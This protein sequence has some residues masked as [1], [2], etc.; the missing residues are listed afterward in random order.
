[1]PISISTFSSGAVI[2]AT[3]LRSRAAAIE[4]YVNKQ[5]EAGDRTT[6]WM[7]SG[8]VYGPDFQYGSGYDA[9][10]PFT[11]GHAY[12]SQRPNDDGRRAIFSWFAG[13]GPAMVPGLTRTIQLPEAMP[14]GKYRA[15]VLA[16][17]WGYEYGGLG[18]TASGAVTPF[19][20][21]GGSPACSFRLYEDGV[22]VAATSRKVYPSSCAQE[23]GW[24]GG[25]GGTY[26]AA[27]GLIYCRKQ[28]SMV[29]AVHW[30]T[31]G[32]HTVGVGVTC[33]AAGAG[34]WKHIFVREGS[35]YVR[36]RIR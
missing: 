9:H 12:W 27:S 25:S 4:D 31:A 6:N 21:E 17:F 24:W 10:L 33:P 19:Q 7:T 1:M 2:S 32:V 16:S 23:N 28:V 3:E 20:T 35:F 30:G 26:G 18:E 29:H 34:Q 36:Y 22:G 8:H 15:L 14:S 11:G 5:I 13:E